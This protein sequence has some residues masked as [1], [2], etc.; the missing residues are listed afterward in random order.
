MSEMQR[1]KGIVKRL[2]SKDNL[3][4]VY[5]KLIA[6]GNHDGQWDDIKE[7]GTPNWIDSEKYTIV[8]GCLFDISNAPDE[9]DEDMGEVND[10]ERL[11]ETDYKIHAYYYNGGAN[12]AEMLSE[13]I[14]I[15]DKEYKKAD[16][17]RLIIEFPS[18]DHREAFTN[19]LSYSGEQ[20]HSSMMDEVDDDELYLYDLSYNYKKSSDGIITTTQI[21]A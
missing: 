17:S 16:N 8:N 18:K 21:E 15:A 11:N 10:A 4:E 2:S 6:D 7:D 12:L 19:W 5:E 14:P 1:N 3:K 9:S 13:S 20:D